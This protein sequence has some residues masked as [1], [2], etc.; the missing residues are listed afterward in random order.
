MHQCIQMQF[1][2][3]IDDIDLLL[4]HFSS[5][6]VTGPLLFSFA[7]NSPW[8]PQNHRVLRVQTPPEDLG[9]TP[10]YRVQERLGDMFHPNKVEIIMDCRLCLYGCRRRPRL[11]FSEPPGVA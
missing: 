7:P 9:P 6:Q 3:N 10:A 5:G 8:V 2:G 1:E 11:A 4:I